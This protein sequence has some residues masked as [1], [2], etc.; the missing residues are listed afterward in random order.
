MNSFTFTLHCAELYGRGLLGCDP[1]VRDSMV[2]RT[3][4]I[5]PEHYW[6]SQPTRTRR[7]APPP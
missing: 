6:V 1:E 2:P 3:V 4:G 7:G 5:L